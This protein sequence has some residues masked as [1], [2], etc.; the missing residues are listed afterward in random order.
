MIQ[1]IVIIN[2]VEHVHS[3][4]FGCHEDAQ[5][6]LLKNESYTA[7][8]GWLE[9]RPNGANLEKTFVDLKALRKP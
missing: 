1:A 8:T 4:A 6:E 7:I 5:E 2:G 9:F 3:R